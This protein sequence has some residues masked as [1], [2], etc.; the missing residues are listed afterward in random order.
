MPVPTALERLLRERSRRLAEVPAR[1]L[2][3]VERV[4]RDLLDRL[5]E[6]LGSLERDGEKILFSGA[7][8]DR[9]VAIRRELEQLLTGGEYARAVAEF[10]GEFTGQQQLTDRAFRLAFPEVTPSDL[11]R[12]VLAT[13]RR[14][15]VDLLAG[16]T[17]ET[18]FLE[19]L[20]DA[21]T[22]AVTSGADWTDTLRE[23]RALVVG[24]A[25]YQ[26]KLE[27]HV[28]QVAWDSLAVADRTYAAAVARDLE[29]E[30]WYYSGGELPT[31]REFCAERRD[32]YWHTEEV[33]GWAALEWDGKM[34][35]ATTADTIFSLLGGWNC[36][37]TLMPVSW[38]V[39][40][41][42]DLA[43]AETAGYW[44]RPVE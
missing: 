15:A 36:R 27:R 22:R 1:L 11:A 44:Q 19:P 14:R 41:E 42:E 34:D 31:T 2:R 12:Q 38:R 20:A 9:V 28:K 29:V 26:A 30:W 5:L 21:L 37:H 43:R 18:N 40:P 33:R 16:A 35:Q 23:L 4:E 13:S 25:D 8:L 7:N 32:R 39:V 17:V 24:D 6:L 10:A 3:R